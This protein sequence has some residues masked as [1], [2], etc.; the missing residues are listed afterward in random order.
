VAA[1]E[2]IHDYFEDPRHAVGLLLD[3]L[4][5]I[6]SVD[7]KLKGGTSTLYRLTQEESMERLRYA[8]RVLPKFIKGTRK[9][10]NGYARRGTASL[11][12][13]AKRVLDDEIKGNHDHLH[14]VIGATWVLV[15]RALSII[16]HSMEDE[17]TYLAMVRSHDYADLIKPARDLIGADTLDQIEAH[18]WF[19][20]LTD[21]KHCGK[22]TRAAFEVAWSIGE[23]RF[24]KRM[25]RDL[26][27]K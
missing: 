16:V 8:V 20:D 3:V 2:P 11:Y 1:S 12:I 22:N 17:K 24:A 23:K 19:R 25:L 14:K 18:W 4:N 7:W 27:S 9:V 15:H 26:S 21:R 5:Q 10:M 6:F 13:E